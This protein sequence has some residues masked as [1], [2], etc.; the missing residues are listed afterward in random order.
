MYSWILLDDG[1]AIDAATLNTLESLYATTKRSAGAE[2][3]FHEAL[4]I[5]RELAECRR[6]SA[7]RMLRES[8]RARASTLFTH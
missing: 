6:R 5:R 2:R 7:G 1:K 8:H 3:S 4:A